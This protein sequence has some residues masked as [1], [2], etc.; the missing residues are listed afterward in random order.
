MVYF[1][2][3]KFITL[4]FFA[5]L[6]S[7]AKNFIFI[8]MMLNF[9]DRTQNTIDSESLTVLTANDTTLKEESWILSLE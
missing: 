7:V 3:I 8:L 1:F 5:T 9:K 4:L 6:F 2:S